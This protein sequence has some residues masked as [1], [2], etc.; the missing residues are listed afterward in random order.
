MNPLS[1]LPSV[2]RL[3]STAALAELV[4][5]HGRAVVTGMVR[6]VLA[7]TRA[8]VKDG[9]P[10]PDEASLLA[11]LINEVGAGVTA[12][13]QPKLRPVF[14]LPAPYSHQPG[15]AAARGSRAGADRRRTFALCA[16][17]RHRVRRPRRPRQRGR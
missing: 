3:L 11:A 10:L 13:M 6:D 15:R 2:D 16:G 12:K 17:I 8:A 4:D 9:T 7:A 5:L 1:Q 14:N